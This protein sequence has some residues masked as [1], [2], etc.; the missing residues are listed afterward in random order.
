[1]SKYV[2]YKRSQCPTVN[3]NTDSTNE[4][5]QIIIHISWWNKCK[6]LVHL[7]W[8]VC[9][10]CLRAKSINFCKSSVFLAAD[11]KFANERLG[12]QTNCFHH[13]RQFVSCRP[14]KKTIMKRKQCFWWINRHPG[15]VSSCLWST[16][17]REW[18]VDIVEKKHLHIV[19]S[20]CWYPLIYQERYYMGLTIR[21]Y[22]SKR[23]E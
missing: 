17:K 14:F 2:F 7:F 10:V 21:T 8:V 20:Q 4:D 23:F 1:M 6:W 22:L 9:I 13:C 18:K 19:H 5:K 11:T 15:E 3:W 12:T 16:V